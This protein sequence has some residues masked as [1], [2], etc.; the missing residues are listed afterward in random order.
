MMEQGRA[1]GVEM[2][3][4]SSPV[5]LGIELIL[6]RQWAGLLALPIVI[7]DQERTVVYYNEPAE[8]V[9]GRRFDEAGPIPWTAWSTS[10]DL[11]TEEGDPLPVEELPLLAA[12][13]EVQ[14]ISRTIGMRS[15]TG[16][17]RNIRNIGIPLLTREDGV[18]GVIGIFW[19]LT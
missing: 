16:T 1:P 4:P 19:V 17:R 13:I 10:F 7:I 6:A 14:P 18:R 11:T 3:G 15:L 2:L 8:I 5:R 12:L 9:L